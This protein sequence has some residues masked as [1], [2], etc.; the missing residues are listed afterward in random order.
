MIMQTKDATERQGDD[1]WTIRS[2]YW[3]SGKSFVLQ[4]EGQ[5]PV[6]VSLFVRAHNASLTLRANPR[7]LSP[8]DELDDAEFATLVDSDYS[9]V[10]VILEIAGI[11]I[12]CRDPYLTIADCL[13]GV[14][15]SSSE[16]PNFLRNP[17]T[18]RD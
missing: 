4:A 8:H 7:E 9:R 3:D 16:L 13:E 17:V 1:L 18:V 14:S 6:T 2:Q 12:A 10:E 11:E 15:S 5:S